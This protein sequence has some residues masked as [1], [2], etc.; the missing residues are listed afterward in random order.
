M[1]DDVATPLPP[2]KKLEDPSKA[3]VLSG[4]L[5]EHD[6]FS[7]QRRSRVELL[8]TIEASDV[9]KSCATIGFIGTGRSSID[10]EDI[11]ALADALMSVGDVDVLNLVVN[12]PGGNGMT[13][14]KIIELCRSYCTTFR[15]II[16]NSAKSAAT[17]IALGADEIV[18]GH[19]SEI[20]PIDAQ[21]PII[22]GGLLR[23]VS[24]QSFINA[25]Q[26]LMA[27]YQDR[28][29]KAKDAKDVLTQLAALDNAFID[30]C[31]KLM[32]FSRDVAE[33]N[34]NDHMFSDLPG[35]KRKAT[36]NTALKELS[37]TEL[38][39]VHGRMINANAAKTRLKLKVRILGKDD[40]LWKTI[41]TY[42]V[43]ADV[44]MSAARVSKLVESREEILIM[45]TMPVAAS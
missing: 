4:I 32:E 2:Y 11:P 39:K 17:I 28:L 45:N 18:M 19:C 13:A 25:R 31:E 6:Q 12:S 29:T 40:A 3:P 14:E 42:Y 27:E 9:G 5:Q 41:W 23:Y 16:P 26:K 35:A 37:A 36:I 44:M 8:K 38:F 30:H 1:P 10:A 15:V 22:F 21:V 33:R 7:Q 43:R 34:L 20:G 24:A